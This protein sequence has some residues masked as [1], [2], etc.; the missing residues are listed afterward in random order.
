MLSLSVST[1]NRITNS[2]FIYDAAG[3]LTADGANTYQWDAESP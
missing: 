1:A 3:N 2:G